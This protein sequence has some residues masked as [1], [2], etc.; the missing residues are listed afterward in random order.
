MKKIT[1]LMLL[2]MMGGIN[3]LFAQSKGDM[4]VGTMLGM[5]IT[6]HTSKYDNNKVKDKPLIKLEIDPGFH[7]FI[8]DN[9]RIG[10]Q[11]GFATDSQKS[12]DDNSKYK[13]GTFVVGGVAAYYF[14]I[15]D[16]FYFTP[17]LGFYFA[18]Q[19]N[20]NEVGST[21]TSYKSNGFLLQILPA[22]LEFRPTTHFGF[23]ASL[24]G[25]ELTHLKSKQDPKAKSN[26]FSFALG[27][28]P[29]IGLKYYF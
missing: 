16:N 23:S 22:M 17:E 11:M 1:I 5:G 3:V 13:H 4:Y 25:L 10:A 28:A 9:F 21:S 15:A 14:Q 19:K 27:L 6:Q 12:H 7:Y 18:H 2:V 8:A 20:T 26:D 29:Q 24:L